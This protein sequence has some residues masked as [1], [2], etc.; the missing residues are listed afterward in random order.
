MIRLLLRMALLNDSVVLENKAAQI[1]LP[2]K[3]LHSNLVFAR[4][5]SLR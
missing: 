3:L 2:G 1:C 5:L 4:V